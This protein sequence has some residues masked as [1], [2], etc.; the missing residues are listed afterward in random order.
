MPLHHFRISTSQLDYFLTIFPFPSP[1]LIFGN[2]V[3]SLGCKQGGKTEQELRE[4][5]LPVEG[6]HL[7]SQLSYEGSKK[8]TGQQV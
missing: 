4:H 5:E 7:S 2:V 6:I 3:A 8:M 1:P